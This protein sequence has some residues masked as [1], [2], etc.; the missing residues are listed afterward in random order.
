MSNKNWVEV[1]KTENGDDMSSEIPMG[2]RSCICLQGCR[3]HYGSGGSDLGL[4]YAWKVDGKIQAH[5][6]QARIPSMAIMFQLIQAA[7]TTWLPEFMKL[8]S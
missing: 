4:R 7:M 2:N 6:G 8:K 3:Y 1:L 5:R